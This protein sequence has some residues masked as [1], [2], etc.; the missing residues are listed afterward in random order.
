MTEQFKCVTNTDILPAALIDGLYVDQ[1]LAQMGLRCVDATAETVQ[2]IIIPDD[3]ILRNSTVFAAAM[4]TAAEICFFYDLRQG[5]VAQRAPNDEPHFGII[6]MAEAVGT[7]QDGTRFYFFKNKRSAVEA[8][9]KEQ[10]YK[11]YVRLNITFAELFGGGTPPPKAFAKAS[12]QAYCNLLYSELR[13]DLPGIYPLAVPGSIR[14]SARAR[15]ADK[16]E[17]AFLLE[18]ARRVAHA[19]RAERSWVRQFYVV[20][21]RD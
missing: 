12:A 9:K 4:E 6:T 7:G 14:D 5:V 2:E 18:Q 10:F 3:P 11:T 19:V 16:F 1:D 8:A 21:R 13:S 20:E 17:K 15:N